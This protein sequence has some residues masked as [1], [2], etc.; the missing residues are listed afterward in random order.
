MIV[1]STV[2]KLDGTSYYSPE[3]RRGGLAASFVVDATHMEGNPTVT[4]TIEHRNADETTFATTGSSFQL[5]AAGVGT[6]DVTGLKEIIRIAVSFDGADDATD[7]IH[8]VIQAPTWR[9]Y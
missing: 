6:V 9:P 1:G 7:A 5:A 3:F 4:F 2:F 8:F